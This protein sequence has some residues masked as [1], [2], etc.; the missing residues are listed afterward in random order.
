MKLSKLRIKELIKEELS[1]ILREQ[2]TAAAHA[3]QGPG[4]GQNPLEGTTKKRCTVTPASRRARAR[5]DCEIYFWSNGKWS[6][7]EDWPQPAQGQPPRKGL[8][9]CEGAKRAYLTK[10]NEFIALQ[11]RA[12]EA[13]NAATEKTFAG[14][15]KAAA[16]K[17]R[18]GAPKTEF[19]SKCMD[20]WYNVS[21]EID[22]QRGADKENY[23]RALKKCEGRWEDHLMDRGT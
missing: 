11:K 10:R 15:E 12:I 18:R 7:C 4:S 9:K 2:P 19:L 1:N 5:M 3:I 23:K 17:R 16:D 22:P 6:L 8:A 14:K 20:K 13:Q 21:L